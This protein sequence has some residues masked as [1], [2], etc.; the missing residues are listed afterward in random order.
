M[1]R[2]KQIMH[3][4]ENGFK[5]GTASR[6]GYRRTA[7]DKWYFAVDKQGANGEWTELMK[8][9]T[10]TA[11]QV[12]RMVKDLEKEPGYTFIFETEEVE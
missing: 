9:N 11:E 7:D 4:T 10:Y 12:F 1:V 3:Y 8:H 5:D 6:T 2:V